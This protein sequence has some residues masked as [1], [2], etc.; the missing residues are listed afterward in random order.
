MSSPANQSESAL[1]RVLMIDDSPDDALLLVE[2]LRNGG[3]APLWR[4]VD[5]EAMLLSALDSD[6]DVVL[7]DYTMPAFSGRRALELVLQNAPGLPFIFVS[8]TLGEDTAVEGLQ[9]GAAD[10]VTKNDLRRLLPAIARERAADRSRRE[11]AAFAARVKHLLSVSADAVI[12]FDSAHCI[13]LWSN[14]ARQ[15]LGYAEH[16]AVGKPLASLVPEDGQS[17]FDQLLVAFRTSD[18]AVWT[19]DER[20]EVEVL[21]SGG[22]RVPVEVGL[23]RYD[24]NGAS[25]FVMV[26]RDIT[27][28]RLSEREMRLLLLIAE[29]ANDGRGL[30]DTLRAGL[31]HL[32]QVL[33]WP[34]AQLW[35]Q[36]RA[37][38]RLACTTAVTA[39]GRLLCES[40]A[41]CLPGA[42]LP[43]RVWQSGQ[44]QWV[45][46]E[47]ERVDT[48]ASERRQSLQ[49]QGLRTAVAVPVVGENGVLAVLECFLAERRPCDERVVRVLQ[50]VA[51][52]IG[53][54]IQRKQIEQRL[55]QL[56]HYDVVTGLPN[57]VLFAD[58]LD[59]ALAETA[60]HGSMLGVIFVDL[61]RFKSINDSFGHEVGDRLLR[62]IAE[63]LQTALRTEDTVARLA[64]DEFGVLVPG[65]GRA[66]DLARV[67]HKLLETF[68][69][70]F[71]IDGQPLSTGASLGLTLYPTDERNASG[72]LRNADGAMYRAK[73]RGGN[74]FCF[75]EPGMTMQA[76]DRLALEAEL[77]TA[78]AGDALSVY[79]QPIKSLP[80]GQVVAVEA[81]VRWQHP[82]RGLLLA[83]SFVSVAEECGL[84]QALG[85]WVL[86]Q[87]CREIGT[88]SSGGALR[89]AVNVSVGQLKHPGFEQR[90]VDVLA[91]T[92]FDPRRLQLEVTEATL[93]QGAD[94]A[95]EMLRRLHEQHGIHFSIDDFGVGYSSFA[96][97][98]RLTV[99]RIKIDPAVLVG[100]SASPQGAALVSAIVA[101]GRSLGIE[102]VAEGVE[103]GEQA[104]LLA[105]CGCSEL[106]GFLVSAPLPAQALEHWLATGARH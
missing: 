19:L 65:L 37:T 100:D 16:E 99:S 15:L 59:Q 69:A 101:L 18:D 24:E 97:L 28:R 85:E 53:N 6:W 89:L 11:Q 86:R 76:T 32:C 2:H 64:G 106:Q 7:A 56:A 49:A 34:Q 105:A 45:E 25:M 39:D 54:A 73:A 8:G 33:G 1:L 80:D 87:A 84:I 21:H 51:A 30:S 5:N 94:A 48:V 46:L 43:G 78:I 66:E 70:P 67:A 82:Q 57:R 55:H 22:Q 40:P 79:Y 10:Y 103:S 3:Y 52:Q 62:S 17:M 95:L 27:Q 75:F 38:G 63:R 14:G 83:D 20:S 72:L 90:V 92:G 47:E 31:H 29:V 35:Q 71:V 98:K 13:S 9:A 42:D 26:L 88:L 4:R 81:L 61:D 68:Q 44:A 96:R 74:V 58:R 77:A 41:T 36:E 23:S 50:T 102:V 104:E 12:G 91:E 93:L 60:R